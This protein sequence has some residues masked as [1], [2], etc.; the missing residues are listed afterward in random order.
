MAPTVGAL[1]SEWCRTSQV[2]VLWPFRNV[3]YHY[4]TFCPASVHSTIQLTED[5][6]KSPIEIGGLKEKRQATFKN[7]KRWCPNWSAVHE[8]FVVVSA[9][10]RFTTIGYFEVLIW[11]DQRN[12]ILFYPVKKTTFEIPTAWNKLTCWN[13]FKDSY[14]FMTTNN[15]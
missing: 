4:Q 9:L 15:S 1:P 5:N 11:K 7:N 12:F 2:R 6:S 13:S 14:Y 10:P 8:T 3:F